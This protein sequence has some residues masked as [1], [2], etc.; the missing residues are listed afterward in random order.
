MLE[1]YNNGVSDRKQRWVT[2]ALL[3]EIWLLCVAGA[4]AQQFQTAAAELRDL[5]HLAERYPRFLQLDTLGETRSGM[6]IVAARLSSSLADTV[7]AVL[8]IGGIDPTDLTSPAVAVGILRYLVAHWDSV[9]SIFAKRALYVIPRLS[10]EPLEGFFERPQRAYVG[11]FRPVDADRD[12]WQDEDD[13]EDIDG[14]GVVR[15]M[16]VYMSGAE[17]TYHP[18]DSALAKKVDA[19]RGEV[20]HFLLVSEGV[21]NDGDE[22]V[23]E[24]QQGGVNID[25][26]FTHRYQPYKPSHGRHPFSEPETRALGFFL[27]QHPE[28]LVV[29]SWVPYDNI[30]FPWQLRYPRAPTQPNRFRKDSFAYRQ[31]VRRVDSLCPYIG[32]RAVPPGSIGEWAFYDA[33]RLS[34]CAPAWAYPPA[35]SAALATEVAP[36]EVRALRWAQLHQDTLRFRPWKPIKH[37]D[38]PE[39]RV[40]VGGF[41]P[42]ALWNPPVDTLAILPQ[43]W[44]PLVLAL[45]EQLPS[46][47]VQAEVHKHKGRVYEVELEM[48]NRGSLP[49]HTVVGR[50]VRALR[51]VHV[52]V[53]LAEGQQLLN[54]PH[55]FVMPEP[56]PAGATRRIPLWILGK[57]E[58][59]ITVGS[60]S[61]GWSTLKVQ[62]R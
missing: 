3:I 44:I 39:Y 13:V 8:L 45:L 41:A 2:A 37:P 7:P 19:E 22:K 38:F 18:D 1:F 40:E 32:E 28:I 61:A 10:P 52:R 55:H 11:N 25:R 27:F 6:P 15:W 54:R 47:T 57:G 9:K 4:A 29:W 24:D 58:V 23:N 49:T 17:W 51:P 5:L 42:F 14:D 30:H 21:D 53:D 26:N 16:R 34:L 56:L 43:R 36:I 31:L 33:G 12:G 20:G 48:S 62:L 35:D 59:S 50:A 46:L 60:P